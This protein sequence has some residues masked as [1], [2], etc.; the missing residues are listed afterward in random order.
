MADERDD[1][2]ATLGAALRIVVTRALDEAA[3]RGSSS[4]EAEHLLLAMTARSTAAARTLAAVGLDHDGVVSAL[5][6]ERTAA[7]AVAGV[8]PVD[9]SR[10]R[11]APSTVR[12]RWGTSMREALRRANTRTDRGHRRRLSEPDLLIGILRADYGTVPR[13]LTLAGVDRSA[14]IERLQRL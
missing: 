12:P 13:A 7:L 2:P 11:A 10:L 5:T 6:Q 8:P 3:A 4:V 9:E 1:T 14:L